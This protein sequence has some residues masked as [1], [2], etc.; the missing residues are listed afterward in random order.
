MN[1]PHIDETLEQ[2][3]LLAETQD[4]A[5]KISK[6]IIALKNRYIEICELETAI[7]KKE[8]RRYSITV[9]ILSTM[10][11]ISLIQIFRLL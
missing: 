7:Y 11:F 9:F 1:D 8:V 10:F 5:L 2:L 6:E 4:E 3:K